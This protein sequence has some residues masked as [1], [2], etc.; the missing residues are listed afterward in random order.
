MDRAASLA[1]VPASLEDL[2]RGVDLLCLDA[3]N[4][5]IFLD[6]ARLAE[7]AAALGHEATASE[8][9]RAEGEAKRRAETGDMVDVPWAFREKPGAAAWGKMVGT[10]AVLAGFPEA[11]VGALLDHVWPVHEAKNLWCRVPEGLGPA[12]DAVR[13]RGVHVAIIS[14]SEGMLDRLFTEL[15]ILGHFDLVVDSGKL[16]VEKPDPRIFEVALA[17][18]AVSPDRALHL[19]DVFATDVL[20]ARAAGMRHA[21]IDPFG[22]YEGRHEDVP[23]VP[24]VVA[25]AQALL[26]AR[27]AP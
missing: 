26:V 14:N 12:L 1:T 8:L 9:V 11:K 18:F 25:V 20:G 19:G 22:H 5:V 10:I 7:L 15:G 13:A 17:H 4:T 27:E 6:H 24:G 21:L 2:V 16:G 3:G 23:R